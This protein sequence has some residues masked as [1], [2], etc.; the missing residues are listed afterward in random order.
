MGA[1][2]PIFRIAVV[3]VPSLGGA[4]WAIG[5]AIVL[6]ADAGDAGENARRARSAIAH[7][8]AYSQ[9]DRSSHKLLV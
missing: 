3:I 9:S 2:V 6:V 4:P 8:R 1:P 7:G 5:D